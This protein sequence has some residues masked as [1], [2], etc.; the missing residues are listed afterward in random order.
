MLRRGLLWAGGIA[1]ALLLLTGLAV[2]VL[3]TGPG[4]AFAARQIG[5]YTLADGLNFRVGRIDGSLY[6]RMVL[7]NV[8]VRDLKG[9]LATSPQVTVDW[10]P[11]AALHRQVDIRVALAPEVD[12]LRAPSIHPS[13]PDAPLL[14]NIDIALGRLAIDRLI[15]EPAVSGLRHIVRLTAST[16]IASGRARVTAD[17]T[18]L[19]APGVAGG[20]RLA[21]HLDAVPAANRLQIDAQLTAPVGGVVDSLTKLGKPLSATIAGRGS[22]TAWA[23]TMRADAG[24]TPL[25]DLALTARNGTVTIRG[26]TAPGLLLTGPAAR[27]VEPGVAVDVTVAL[28]QRRVT[29]AAKLSS[30]AFGATASGLVDLGRNRFGDLHLTARLLRP[31]VIAPN[32][33][34]RNLALDA[35]VDGPFGT[36]AVDYRVSGTVLAFGTTTVE[37]FVASGRTTVDANRILIPV[38]AR[39]RRVTGGNVPAGG[40][41][42]NLAVDGDLAYAHGTLAS[43]NL[44]LRSDRIAATAVVAADPAK[45]LYTGALKGRVNDYAVAGVGRVDVVTDVH[46][47]T[48][49]GGGFGLAGTVRATTRSLVDGSLKTQLGGNAVATAAF[50]YV[51]GGAATVR[52][53]RLT[54]PKLRITV[55][56]G[57]YFPDGRIVFDASAVSVPYGPVV[58]TARGTVAR[59]V[60][61]LVAAH[62]NVGVQLTGV[63]ATLTGDGTG[64]AITARG[65]SPYGPFSAD[66]R[67]TTG[68]LAVDI[69]AARFAG[70]D[71]RGRIA[72]TAGGP[73]A[74]RLTV[75]GSGF[76]GSVVLAAAGSV[77]RADIDLAAHA[78]KIPGPTP[79]TVGGGSIRAMVVLTPGT[80]SVVADV[81]LTD[82]RS[83]TLTVAT[84]RGHADYR[85]GSGAV[86][87]VAGG[88]GA[89]PF[90]IR[91]QA[92]LAPGRIVANAAGS[93]DHVAFHL[94]A[95]ATA[96]RTGNDWHLAPVTLVLP[97]GS[98]RLAAQYGTMTAVQAVIDKL[99]LAIVEPFAPDLGLGGRLG[100]T[101][102]ATLPAGGVPAVDA[103]LTVTGFTRTAAYTRSAP[104]DLD[105]RA[106]LGTAGGEVRGL[107]RRGGVI[108][109]RVD[110][111]LAPLAGGPTL[112]QRLLGAPLSGGVRYNGPSEVLWALT[113][114]AGQS[115][116][117]PVVVAADFGGHLDR[118]MV[119]GVLRATALR[120]RNE[121]LGTAITGIAVEGRFT[122]ARLILTSLTG[123]AGDGTIAASGTIGLDAAAGFPVDL[124]VTLTNARLAKSDA[125][126]ATATGTLKITNGPGGG[127][128]AGTLTIP[129]ARYQIIRQGAA[130]VAELTGVRRRGAPPPEAAPPPP[131]PANLRLD[132][133]IVAP[134]RIFISGMGLEA[135]WSTDMH[136]TGTAAAPVVIG[137]IK[138]VRG[139]YSF[140][141][142]Q[143]DLTPDGSISFDGGDYTDPQLNLTATTTVEGVTATINI[144]GRAQ[145]PKISF[146]STP[147]LPQDEVLS[148]LLFGTSVTSLSPIQALQLA[149]ALNS[150]RGS[151]GGLNPLGKLRS[152]IGVSRLRVLGA[153][154][155]TGRGTSLAAGQYIGKNIYVEVITDARG[156]TATQLTI[157]L[158][159]ALSILSQTSSFGGSNVSLRYSKNY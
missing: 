115:L 54:A 145:R 19:A 132:I 148:R 152:A 134:R 111:R 25:A 90:D 56:G 116:D 16:D 155:A 93:L 106:T 4:R 127:L 27:L 30:N 113:G 101:V 18:A 48:P 128:I 67:V 86:Q 8:E 85:G 143:F 74:G 122:Q 147:A 80:P 63:E 77:Q 59:P 41:L 98:V 78:A 3:D 94:A 109:G 150:L 23:G 10:R 99:D 81:A 158:S 104:V 136:V 154:A 65:G 20:D 110:A 28:A 68:P 135:E 157:S 49:R 73:F 92:R 52:D 123:R 144:G 120:Y 71:F 103:R 76:N 44:R 129:E 124:T 126:G 11:L 91:A 118:P 6:G 83:G 21:L 14:P 114:I 117:G 38:H 75:A 84:L 97:Q 141:G 57:T 119:E 107:I 33:G 15:L 17:A 24:G 125:L 108:I 96:T 9:L 45:G 31:A 89:T 42:T 58:V 13:P 121:K 29:V 100:G 50:T 102:T 139:T 140:A 47:T 62:P 26:T 32:L 2:A 61:H 7:R 79:V 146:T 159:R 153:D 36:P 37:D 64:Y 156:F 55:G 39:A 138:V 112:S 149:A 131:G 88:G 105:A 12:M 22:W 66:T 142:R 53:L 82:V 133:H 40:L 130:E 1:V 72:A 69:R 35:V 87:L 60:V 51:P 5:G 137:E 95:P 70:I 34:G 46:L 151:G 43:D